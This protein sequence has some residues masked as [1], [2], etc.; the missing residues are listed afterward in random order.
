MWKLQFESLLIVGSQ[1]QSQMACHLCAHSI[2][3]HKWHVLGDI[4]LKECWT[5]RKLWEQALP[6]LYGMAHKKRVLI[7]VS[8]VHS[9]ALNYSDFFFAIFRIS[10]F[11]WGPSSHSLNIWQLAFQETGLAFSN[12]LARSKVILKV[13]WIIRQNVKKTRRSLNKGRLSAAFALKDQNCLGSR[14]D[15]P[16]GDIRFG[17]EGCKYQILSEK[18]FS[19]SSISEDALKVRFPLKE[20][21]FFFTFVDHKRQIH[22]NYHSRD[23]D[24]GVAKCHE[25]SCFRTAAN[26]F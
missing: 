6:K 14:Y 1:F 26:G 9:R 17:I 24:K 19:C 13:V 16:K 7:K 21:D 3:L 11:D 2:C 5:F 10:S 25:I 23:G 20:N 4:G 8:F 12:A 22:E 18:L 15:L